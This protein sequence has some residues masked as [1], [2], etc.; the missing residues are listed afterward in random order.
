MYFDHAAT[1][2]PQEE[3][4][5]SL[6]DLSSLA[7][8]NPSSS[9][10]KGLEVRRSLE[11]V[12]EKLARYMGAKPGEIY[13]TSGAT[14]AN[15]IILQGLARGR[16]GHIIS[17]GVE[18]DSVEMALKYLEKKGIEVS[19][20][21]P[22]ELLTRE[23]VLDR[24]RDNTFLV[25]LIKVQ[26]ETGDNYPLDGLG[27]ELRKR[28]IY[29]HRDMVQALGKFRINLAEE[30]LDF[31]SFSSH[32][33][34]GLK[35]LGIL[36]KREGLELDPLIFGGGQE[37][38]L[39]PGTENTLAILAL[40]W[41]LDRLNLESYKKVEELNQLMRRRF[42]SLGGLIISSETASPYIL[43][44]SFKPPSE[45]LLTALSSRGV[46]ASAGSAC[47]A[48]SG[49]VARIGKYLDPELLRGMVRFSL[50]SQTSLEETERMLDILEETLKELERYL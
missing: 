3:L 36:F 31:A 20:L 15:N 47:H 11:E 12:R 22:K 46:Y 8:Y 43:A 34:G 2:P 37:R 48:G 33:L 6:I 13:F 27:R 23:A 21:G 32:K 50:S 40:G 7:A 5:N 19:R 44:A 16:G 41:V 38:D 30:A 10:F 25:S 28:G 18:H 35:G 24:V 45:V 4:N 1:S 26:N 29:Y 39:R 49:R 42:K 14:E 17:S 9:H